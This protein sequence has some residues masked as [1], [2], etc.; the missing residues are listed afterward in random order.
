MFAMEQG[1][2]IND[3]DHE[4]NIK[5]IRGSVVLKYAINFS[6]YLTHTVFMRLVV[7]RKRL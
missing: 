7:F 2:K 4:R 5:N 3:E 6:P 1:G